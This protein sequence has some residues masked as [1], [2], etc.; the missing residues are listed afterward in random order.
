MSGDP[1]EA[2]VPGNLRFLKVLVTI[3]TATM[4]LGLLTIIVLIVIRV[5]NVV[6]VVEDQVPLPEVLTLPDGV[7]AEA[8]TL[9]GDWI[10]VVVSGDEILIFDR[11]S[12][13]LRQRIAIAGK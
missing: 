5:P 10:A 11:E 6:R 8:V 12:G 4:I 9:G 7:T 3:L 13:A 2:G 1:N